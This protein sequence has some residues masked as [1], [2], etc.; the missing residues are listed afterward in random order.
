MRFCVLGS[1]SRG[2]ATLVRAGST[3]ILIDNG[4][5]GRNLLD[6]L[7]AVGVGPDAL[8]AIVLTH[9]HHDHCRGVGVLARRL[10]LAV[11]ANGATLRA[12]S[13]ILGKLPQVREFATGEAFTFQDMEI[14]PFALSHDAADPV[15]FRVSDGKADFGYCTDTGTIT[16]L[17][18]HHLR[19][20][21]GVVL[22]ANHDPAMLWA[23]PYPPH[24]K[25]RISSRQGH[26]AN[27]DSAAFL[28][29][30]LETGALGSLI[31]AHLSETNNQA[32]LVA[33]AVADLAVGMD[34]EIARQDRP[35]RLLPV[36]A[37]RG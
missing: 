11:F 13:H 4:F 20:C 28:A 26:L 1:G 3:T 6:R 14:H 32:A 30:L 2:N 33:R 31:L 9:E 17:I 22:E 18:A 37:R 29:E 25:Q 27:G 15:G 7:R 21:Q 19:G 8:D 36:R 34:V 24:L 23:G 35:T 10:G 12:A 5:S 16:R